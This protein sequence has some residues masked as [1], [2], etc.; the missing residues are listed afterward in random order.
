LL[1]EYSNNPEEFIP[2]VLNSITISMC[3]TFSSLGAAAAAHCTAAACRRCCCLPPLPLVVVP[4]TRICL[5]S[6][7]GM[8]AAIAAAWPLLPASF[9]STIRGQWILLIPL[10]LCRHLLLEL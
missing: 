2:L 4:V 9:V 3:R 1:Q 7:A 5:V 6:A 8:S 10:L